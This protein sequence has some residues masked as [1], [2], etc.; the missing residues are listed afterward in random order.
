MLVAVSPMLKL[1]IKHR[2]VKL[3]SVRKVENGKLLLD[4]EIPANTT[5]TVYFPASTADVIMEGGKSVSA[6]KDIQIK[7]TDAGYVLI[8][9]GSGKHNFSTDWKKDPQEKKL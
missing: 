5:V 6:A 7:G 8:S 3:S 9:V 4:A 1:P 2:Y